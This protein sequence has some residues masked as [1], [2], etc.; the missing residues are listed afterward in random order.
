MNRAWNDSIRDLP[1]LAKFIFLIPPML[2]SCLVI[3]G[4][5]ICSNEPPLPAM[6]LWYSFRAFKKREASSQC[7]ISVI[8]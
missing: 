8:R 4:L 7:D 5:A 3:G 2:S 6:R 1:N